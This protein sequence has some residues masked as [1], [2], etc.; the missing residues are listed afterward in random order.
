MVVE[1]C[2][3]VE[4]FLSVFVGEFK[5][6]GSLCSATAGFVLEDV[7]GSDEPYPGARLTYLLV[8]VLGNDLEFPEEEL[9]LALLVL[10]DNLAVLVSR[11]D[12]VQVCRMVHSLLVICFHLK[13]VMDNMTISC[14]LNSQFF[15]FPEA[16]VGRL[17]H[18][19]SVRVFLFDL[20]VRDGVANLYSALTR[21][22]E[23]VVAI[24][25]VTRPFDL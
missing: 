17:E 5:I 2:E 1:D 23:A 24:H 20:C 25:P 8:E 19:G 16:K 9:S 7:H 4:M 11:Q 22:N 21:R 3:R 15:H 14:G 13:D 6:E 10:Y 18:E 12:I